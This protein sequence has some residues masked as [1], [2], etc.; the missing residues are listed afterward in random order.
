MLAHTKS[1]IYVCAPMPPPSPSPLARIV[2]LAVAAEGL[3]TFMDALIKLLSARYPAVQI[4]FLR[5]GFG[6]VGA[7][8]YAA[9]RPPGWPTREALLFNGI[10]AV[11]IVVTATTFFFALARLPLADAIA[12]SFIAPVLTALF[13]IS[14]LGEQ[15]DWRIAVALMAGF[16]GMVLIVGGKIGSAGLTAEVAIGAAAVVL[17]AVGYALNIIVL[18]HRAVRDPLSQIVLFQNL[19]PTLLLAPAVVWVWEPLTLADA[20]L[21]ALI[22]SIGVAAHTMLAHAFA[23]IEATR[24][25]PVGYVTL[26]WG[27]LFGYMFFAEIP[28]LAALGGAALIVLGTVL[29]RPR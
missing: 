11:L 2:L 27:V 4:A 29:T 19:G 8:L 18:R 13:G 25:A 9:W 5:F 12:L 16:A 21:F 10:R 24:L 17:S 14:L 15:R 6:L 28:G 26:V 22:G 23:R 20:A 7:A 1:D 3:L